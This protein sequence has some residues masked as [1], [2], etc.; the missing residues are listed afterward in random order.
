[1]RPPTFSGSFL[2]SHVPL[3][4]G[5]GKFK[6]FDQS[7]ASFPSRSHWHHISADLW[8][9]V[10]VSN[11]QRSFVMLM[12]HWANGFSFHLLLLFSPHKHDTKV[13]K[14][15]TPL[16]KKWISLFPTISMEEPLSLQHQWAPSGLEMFPRR[17][18][19][20][21]AETKSS[22]GGHAGTHVCP[23]QRDR[24]LGL[25]RSGWAPPWKGPAPMVKAPSCRTCRQRGCGTNVVPMSMRR[26]T[27]NAGVLPMAVEHFHLLQGVQIQEATRPSRPD[28]AA[29]NSRIRDTLSPPLRPLV[30]PT[31]KIVKG[32]TALPLRPSGGAKAA[33][34][35]PREGEASLRRKAGPDGTS[36]APFTQGMR[37]TWCVFFLFFFF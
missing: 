8:A 16:K 35:R 15:E 20:S 29:V 1:M 21:S 23:S 26:A 27:T 36:M 5:N 34:V 24:A 6:L 32:A 28:A 10:D 9:F 11:Q 4:L 37:E 3:I 12:T 7:S 22:L 33:G 30:P 31:V 25:K 17:R 14:E 2:H 19:A 18:E 13:N